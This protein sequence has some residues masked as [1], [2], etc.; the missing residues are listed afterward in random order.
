MEA[1][2]FGN[3]KGGGDVGY[4]SDLCFETKHIA[5]NVCYTVLE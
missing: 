2:A 5:G 4:W 1:N 3:S